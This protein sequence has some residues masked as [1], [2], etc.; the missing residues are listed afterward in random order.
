M[1]TYTTRIIAMKDDSLL[2]FAGPHVQS[3]SFAHAQAWC[4]E[5][6]LGYCTV[7]GQLLEIIP[8][9]EDGTPDYANAIKYDNLN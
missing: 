2:E 9:K 7:D 1:N 4:E 6:G 8:T 3:I 5:N